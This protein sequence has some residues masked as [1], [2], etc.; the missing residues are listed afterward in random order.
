MAITT[1]KSDQLTNLDASPSVIE[2]SHNL[3]GRLR[4]AYF[5]H[6][7]SGTGDAG[8]SFEAV[9]LPPGKV[10]IL[11]SLCNLQVSVAASTPTIDVGWD[12]YTDLDGTAVAA[13]PD[14]IVDGMSVTTNVGKD[15]VGTATT[16]VLGGATMAFESQDA[17]SIRITSV[18]ARADAEVTEGY[19]VYVQD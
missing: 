17:V 7:Q 15:L 1:Q 9:R 12:A 19:I 14:G 6:T 18:V 11:G 8:S 10:R 5:K 3:H 13:D 4:V 2:N 16:G